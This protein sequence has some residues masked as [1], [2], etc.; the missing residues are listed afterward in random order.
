METFQFLR[1]VKIC[2][3]FLQHALNNIYYLVKRLTR[4]WSLHHCSE[5]VFEINWIVSEESFSCPTLDSSCLQVKEG[6]GVCKSLN[7]IYII[8]YLSLK[9]GYWKF[10]SYSFPTIQEL[11]EY[12]HSSGK[13]VTRRSGAQLKNP[14][15]QARLPPVVEVSDLG[16]SGVPWGSTILKTLLSLVLWD[17]L[18]TSGILE[19]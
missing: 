8:T 2:E 16:E 10:E 19:L 17:Q 7:T 12:Q 1:D 3:I 14:I 15:T 13:P 6:T 18:K 9:K 4:G 11:I 5:Y